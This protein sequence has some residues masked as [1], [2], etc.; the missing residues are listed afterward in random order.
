MKGHW[1]DRAFP[2]VF[3]TIFGLIVAGVCVQC[4]VAITG[5]EVPCETYKNVEA[6]RMP[7]RCL[8]EFGIAPLLVPR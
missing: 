5:Y 2:Y 1:T 3:F 7:A 6:R 8:K 4:V